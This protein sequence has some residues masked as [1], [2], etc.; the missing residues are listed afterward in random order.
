MTDN[1]HEQL[2]H[3]PSS[4]EQEKAEQFDEPDKID[5]TKAINQW[6]LLKVIEEAENKTMA[7]GDLCRHFEIED[8][9]SERLWFPLG[10]LLRAGRIKQMIGR[11]SGGRTG[12]VFK[13]SLNES[14]SRSNR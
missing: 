9:E 5:Q 4:E 2:V 1:E 8:R 10:Q 11:D 6:R 3:L 14:T 12:N 13:V 7:L